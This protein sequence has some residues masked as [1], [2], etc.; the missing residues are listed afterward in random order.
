MCPYRVKR[1]ALFLGLVLSACAHQ[2]PPQEQA[3]E[4][5]VE[6]ESAEWAGPLACHASNSSGTWAFAAPGTVTVRPSATPL[7]IACDVPTGAVAE[8]N[9]IA[10]NPLSARERSREGAS[11]GTKVGAGAGVVLG[12]AAA[13]VMGGPFALLIA[14]GAALKGREVGG[15]VGALRK[16]EQYQYPSPVVLHIRS[17]APATSK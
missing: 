1:N 15:L 10:A 16:G 2:A 3:I 9:A 6:A 4:V 8:S 7:Q 11:V 14:A 5:R 12:A 17:E 13:P